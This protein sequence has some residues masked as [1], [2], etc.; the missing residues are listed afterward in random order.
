MAE[1]E[2][3]EVP[4]KMIFLFFG[5]QTVPK[6]TV[7][8]TIYSI[9]MVFFIDQKSIKGIYKG[10]IDQ[11]LS[12]DSCNLR[13]CLSKSDTIFCVLLNLSYSALAFWSAS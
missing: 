13:I 5:L 4:E 9:C 7:F 6:T 8:D 11:L 2:R 1:K 10:Q 3:F 12:C